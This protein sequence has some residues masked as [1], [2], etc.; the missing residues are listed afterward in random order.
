MENHVVR[1]GGQVGK[2]G[3]RE[4]K[5]GKKKGKGVKVNNGQKGRSLE[6]ESS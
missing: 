2:E 6:K 3:I 5:K 4:G 1:K